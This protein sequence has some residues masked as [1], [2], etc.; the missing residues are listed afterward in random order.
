MLEA[1][2]SPGAILFA[3]PKPPWYRRYRRRIV[4]TTFF[5][6]CC[7]AGAACWV[8][9]T[10]PLSFRT[11]PEGF[12]IERY[13]DEAHPRAN[14]YL[15]MFDL[16]FGNLT[17][18]TRKFKA[19]LPP[20]YPARQPDY[21]IVD[22]HGYNTPDFADQHHFSGFYGTV[23][24]QLNAIVVTTWGSADTYSDLAGWNAWGWSAN[25]MP[26][27]GTCTDHPDAT[28]VENH[29]PYD[30]Y[31]SQV[32][33]GEGRC[34]GRHSSTCSTMSAQD[35]LLYVRKVVTFVKQYWT[36]TAKVVLTG[37][38]MGGIL[39]A[40]AAQEL[41]A[42]GLVDGALPVSA[43][44]A[45]NFPRNF[46]A[47]VPILHL[48]GIYDEWIPTCVPPQDIVSAGFEGGTGIYSV[49]PSTCDDNHQNS[50]CASAD[51]FLYTPLKTTLETYARG[52]S[53]P[54]WS[55]LEWD[56]YDASPYFSLDDKRNGTR[57]RCAHV[58]DSQAC[59]GGHPCVSV[60]LFNGGHCL[61]FQDADCEWIDDDPATGPKHNSGALAFAALLAQ[62][63]EQHVNVR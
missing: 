42:D 43:G 52:V 18:F 14:E 62:W 5:L 29:D 1:P 19:L 47:S 57:L 39:S 8:Y 41:V 22:S 4:A 54:P 21:I 9:F 20:S 7:G 61:P 31:A 60:C 17:L 32:L 27:N 37:Q 24:E 34:K 25:T 15:I 50:V 3:A 46:E 10:N 49:S 63:L 11:L 53:L 59:N 6:M 45:R 56:S 51:G 48:H 40:A 16:P 35:D 12:R 44:G 30:C 33:T 13:E 23:V 2:L 58:D 26:T 55:Q 36:N 28:C 38:S